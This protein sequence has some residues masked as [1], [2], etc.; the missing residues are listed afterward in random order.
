MAISFPRDSSY[1]TS[2]SQRVLI[3]VAISFVVFWIARLAAGLLSGYHH[4]AATRDEQLEGRRVIHPMDATVS[5]LHNAANALRDTFISLAV[6]SLAW[7]Q[8][9][10]RGNGFELIA[11]IIL[12]LSLIWAATK[13]IVFRFSDVLLFIIIPLF[14]ALWVVTL[15]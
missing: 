7:R 4:R 15:F 3:I 5:R 2:S 1:P 6:V 10:S 9:N 14:V 13:T 12:G 11:W 8:S